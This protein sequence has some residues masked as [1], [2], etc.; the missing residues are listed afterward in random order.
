MGGWSSEAV[1]LIAAMRMLSHGLFVL[2]LGRVFMLSQFVQEGLI[3]GFL[4]RPM[5]VYRQVQ[6]AYFPANAIGDLLVGGSMFAG[7]VWRSDLHWTVARSG[8]ATA[9]LIGGM[10]ME[11]A[12]FTAISSFH[13]HHPA[14]NAWSSWTEELLA[15]FG[16]YP[17]KILPGMISG[18]LTFGLPLAFVAYFPAAVLT[19]NTS[20]LGVPVVLAAASPLVGLAAFAGSRLLWNRRLSRYTGVNG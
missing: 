9:A 11:G 19:G 6:L 18:V 13:L 5:P 4:L 15:T 14:A 12:I 2:F 16:N 10:L 17:L 7:A 3:D 20:G 8:Y 1:L